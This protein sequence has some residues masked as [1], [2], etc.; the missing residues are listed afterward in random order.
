M[1]GWVNG[2]GSRWGFH[3]GKA[4]GEN[5][6]CQVTGSTSSRKLQS[7][8]LSDVPRSVTQRSPNKSPKL[9]MVPCGENGEPGA[10][11]VL[12]DFGTVIWC[13]WTGLTHSLLHWKYSA[14]FKKLGCSPCSLKS[15][16]WTRLPYVGGERLNPSWQDCQTMTQ[17]LFSQTC[18]V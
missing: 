6:P 18:A 13:L 5:I 1:S 17:M 12:G 7:C 9:R 14:M 16:R 11:A 10:K 8:K 4:R 3:G 2:G 15:Q